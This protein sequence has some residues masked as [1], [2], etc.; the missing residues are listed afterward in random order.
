MNEPHSPTLRHGGNQQIATLLQRPRS[1]KEQGEL[2]VGGVPRG[3][4]KHLEINTIRIHK[5]LGVDSWIAAH[6]GI[7]FSE[8]RA[9]VDRVFQA[10]QDYRDNYAR[11]LG[12]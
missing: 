10:R 8:T 6:E 12:L 3:G 5:Q 4:R 7:Q 11:E 2:F 1:D 9:Y